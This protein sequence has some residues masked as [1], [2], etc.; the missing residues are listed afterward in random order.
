MSRRNKGPTPE[1]LIEKLQEDFDAWKESSSLRVE[2]V[3][4]QGREGLEEARGEYQGKLAAMVEEQ[5][6]PLL[7]WWREGPQ[8]PLE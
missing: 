1:E 2:E 6:R 7:Y 4:R 8:G 5:V 3:E